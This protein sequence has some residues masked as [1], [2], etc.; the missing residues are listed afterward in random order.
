MFPRQGRKDNCESTLRHR[1]PLSSRQW[2]THFGT[3]VT[4]TI[5]DLDIRIV[6][7][8][9]SE[10]LRDLTLNPSRDYQPVERPKV[11]PDPRN[12]KS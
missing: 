1:L 11:R 12:D 2:R 10:I 8:I 3:H 6:N 7:P 5:R 9:T 4:L